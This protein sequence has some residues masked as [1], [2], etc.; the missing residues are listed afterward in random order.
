[1]RQVDD[2]RRKL[3]VELMRG[4]GFGI[5]VMPQGAFHGFAD[6][7]RWI[8]DSYTFAFEILEKAGFGEAPGV[9]LSCPF[10]SAA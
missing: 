3:M 7:S 6:A 2:R 5:P 1:M 8:D 4:V 9:V 10:G